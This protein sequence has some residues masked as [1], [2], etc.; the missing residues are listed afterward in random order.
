MYRPVRGGV[1]MLAGEDGRRGGE[2]VVVVVVEF[3]MGRGELG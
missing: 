1:E 2:V 3:G